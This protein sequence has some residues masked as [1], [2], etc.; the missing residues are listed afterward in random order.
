MR[1][2]YT[3]DVIGGEK[4]LGGGPAR[5]HYVVAGDNLRSLAALYY[6]SPDDWYV[7]ADANG[8]TGSEE[9]QARTP[10][11]IPNVITN[12]FNNNDTYTLYSESDIIGGDSAVV[13][14]QQKDTSWWEDLI[15]VIIIIIIV[16][17]MVLVAIY[18]PEF[19]GWAAGLLGAA[20]MTGV[21][22]TI[23]AYAATAV[24]GYAVGYA[25]SFLTQ[26]I[27]ILAGLQ[28][29]FDWKAMNDMG[30][31]MAVSAVSASAL[32]WIKGSDL[33]VVGKAAAN[34]GV[35]AGGQLIQNDGKINNVSGIV[36][37]MLPAVGGSMK[38]LGWTEAGKTV[39][40]FA[41]SKYAGAGLAMLE[42]FRKQARPVFSTGPVSP[43]P[44]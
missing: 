20:G 43:P 26:G 32:K 22:V 35:A 6:G 24:V 44:R 42:N 37:A 39:S 28:E 4:G 1:R 38:D 36:L 13:H 19:E 3:Y 18:A 41:D 5:T 30:K 34:A 7:I 17:V 31:S 25:T 14:V 9:L 29:D 12:S 33:S 23:A 27:A 11:Q 2:D 10:L 15:Q 8:L 16:V 40:D 21:A